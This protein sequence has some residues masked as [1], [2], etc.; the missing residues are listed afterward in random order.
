[1]STTSIT[2]A[3]SSTTTTSTFC[4]ATT[5]SIA[6]VA[7]GE[8]GVAS[9]CGC[10][11]VGIALLFVMSPPGFGCCSACDRSSQ[12]HVFV[13]VAVS[14]L[15]GRRCALPRTPPALGCWRCLLLRLRMCLGIALLFIM[16]PPGFACCPA[17]Y[18][19]CCLA[20]LWLLMSPSAPHHCP[21]S[22]H[23]SVRE[24]SRKGGEACRRAASCGKHVRPV[25]QARQPSA[26]GGAEQEQ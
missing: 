18:R 4:T 22:M 2:L 20:M 12:N 3:S 14:G 7:V 23:D 17:R 19:S 25:A 21:D 8:V 24:S 1:M 11:C 6:F 5:R 16:P 13:V 26:E 10:A 9:C 15:R